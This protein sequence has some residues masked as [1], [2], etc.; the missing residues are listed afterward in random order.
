MPQQKDLRAW[1][2]SSHLAGANA[3]WLEAMYEDWLKDPA[4]VD[5]GWRAYF[6]RLPRAESALPER[7]QVDIRQGFVDHAHQRQQE[8]WRAPESHP[9]AMQPA[10]PLAPAES[11]QAIRQSHV[12]QLVDAYRALG[13]LVANIDPLG[14]RDI[15]RLPELDPAHYGLVGGLIGRDLGAVFEDLP[16]GLRGRS[17]AD[18]VAGLQAIYCGTFAIEYVHVANS[19][20]LCWLREALE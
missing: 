8:N 1:W 2:N 20:E 15:P 3:S 13:H 17:L 11:P 18:V 5:A 12:R 19:V 7:S 14:L 10:A 4:A 9:L 16:A 6:E